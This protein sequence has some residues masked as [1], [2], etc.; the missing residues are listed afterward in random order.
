MERLYLRGQLAASCIHVSG[1]RS[2]SSREWLK[3]GCLCAVTI[4]TH[5]L[6]LATAAIVSHVFEPL[7]RSIL[8][9]IPLSVIVYPKILKG[10]PTGLHLTLC[11]FSSLLSHRLLYN[12]FKQ[13]YLN[14]HLKYTYKKKGH[15][16]AY[17]VFPKLCNEIILLYINV[18]I[19]QTVNWNHHGKENFYQV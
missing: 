13:Q 3:K 18:F 5:P 15:S 4:P 8:S 12:N 17:T 14:I 6:L 10:A 9:I 2:G 11:I 1:V 16:E 19:W 7:S